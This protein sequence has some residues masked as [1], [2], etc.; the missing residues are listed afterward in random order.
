M[1][2]H[3]IPEFAYK[4]VYDK[5]H[6]F[7]DFSE[8]PKTGVKFAQKGIRENLLCHNCEEL[9]SKYEKDLYDF[10]LNLNQ[11]KNN[12][13]SI[14]DQYFLNTKIKYD[15]IKIAILSIAYRLSVS[16]LPQYDGYQL[17]PYEEI[18]R[19]III[20]GKHIDRYTFSTH[21]SPV[22]RNG[23]YYPDLIMT[24]EK[25]SKY[26]NQYTILCFILYG[27]L[28]DVMTSKIDKNDIW[29]FFSLREKGKIIMEYIDITDVNIKNGL[30]KRF[31]DEDVKRLVNNLKK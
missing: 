8:D 10:I 5:Q 21:I 16:K 4:P 23:I 29:H 20:N 7:I 1:K 22:T 2:S 31:Q 25:L 11:K 13:Y 17:G 27:L 12:F 9:L 3:I 15:S 14:S 6:R 30:I 26:K 18:I 19:D 28:F 24:Y